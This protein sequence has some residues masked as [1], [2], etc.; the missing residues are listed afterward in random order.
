MSVPLLSRARTQPTA[1]QVVNNSG[2][3]IRHLYLSPADRDEWSPDQLN[4]SVIHTGETYTL[5]SVSCGQSEI[6]LIAEDQNGCFFSQVVACSAGST[7]TIPAGATPN[8]GN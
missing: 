3:E 1:I 2:Q 6:K 8:C 5:D 4:N 7:W